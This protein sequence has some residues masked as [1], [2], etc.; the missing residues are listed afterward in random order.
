MAE[1][2]SDSDAQKLKIMVIG[3]GD[4]NLR[5]LESKPQKLDVRTVAIGYDK[6]QLKFLKIEK[7]SGYYASVVCL[8]VIGT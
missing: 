3:I 1:L 5:I 6:D 8:L 4:D 7:K 2:K